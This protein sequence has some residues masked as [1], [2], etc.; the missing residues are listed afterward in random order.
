[1][2]SSILSGTM[3]E[4]EI[5]NNSS[6]NGDDTQK[7]SGATASSDKGSSSSSRT[8][9]MVASFFNHSLREL[10]HDPAWLELQAQADAE[11]LATQATAVSRRASRRT[12]VFSHGDANSVSASSTTM[13]MNRR[14]QQQIMLLEKAF[15]VIDVSNA[16]YL[17]SSDLFI[18]FQ[19]AAQHIGLKSVEDELIDIVVDALLEDITTAAKNQTGG[20]GAAAAAPAA[21]ELVEGHI[22]KEQFFDIFERHPDLMTAFGDD[23]SRSTLAY[24][25]KKHTLDDK[26]QEEE[27]EWQENDAQVWHRYHT[28]LQNQAVEY[29]WLLLY[30]LGSIAI[31]INKAI[32]YANRQDA[33]DVFGYCILPA[34]GAAACLN[35]NCLF[36]LLPIC[37]HVTTWVQCTPLHSYFPFNAYLE[38]HV[39]FGTAILFWAMVHVGAHVCDFYRFAYAPE[40]AIYALFGDKLGV[41]PQDP[42]ARIRLLLKQ[43]AA[44]TGIIMVVCILIAYPVVL[45]RRTKFNTFWILHHLLLVML[46]ALC[47]HGIASLLEPYASVY[48]VIGPLVIYTLSRLLRETNLS[49]SNVLLAQTKSGGIVHLQLKKPLGWKHVRSGM[50]AFLKVPHISSMEWHPLTLTSTPDDPYL[51]F[52]FASVGDWTDA[53][54]SFLLEQIQ[55]AKKENGGEEGDGVCGAAAAGTAISLE[56]MQFKVDGPMGAS[57]QGF[58]DFEVVVLVGAGKGLVV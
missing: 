4:V 36:I 39:L 51:E 17:T 26:E 33:L 10:T 49:D 44:I 45:V 28:N 52:H 9:A 18:F 47:C 7:S 22:T 55:A 11:E 15:S 2:S 23:M 6:N 20:A 42:G 1:M 29:S 30:I 41:V 8:Q 58:M 19:Q 56:N 31:F 13:K 25:D 16:G 43:P 21:T 32:E 48:Y 40:D 38:A 12:S 53:V 35:V 27:E 14:K 3:M 57:S 37:R 34:R 5:T 46:I 50:Y 54:Q 24:Y